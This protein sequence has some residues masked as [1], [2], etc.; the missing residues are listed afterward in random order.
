MDWLYGLLT[1]A[2]LA[3]L[4]WVGFR[5]EPHRV[6]KDG[7][8]MLCSGQMLSPQGDP[9]TK[10]RE[11]RVIIEKD[12]QLQVDQKRMMRRK[13]RMWTLSAESPEPPKRRA[14]F[15]LKSHDNDGQP[16]MMAI[17]M[18]D[19]SRAVPVLRDILKH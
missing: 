14:L 4:V 16:I 7:R 8:F 5:M 18:P 9:L 15:L 11:T 13:S 3:L 6:S 12:G 1:I 2:V 10:W 17:R 19:K